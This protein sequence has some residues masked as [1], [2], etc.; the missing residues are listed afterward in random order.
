M[1]S[2]GGE[3]RRLV[4]ERG[5]GNGRGD[6][7]EAE[8]DGDSELD[9][10]ELWA[11]G[12]RYSGPSTKILRCPCNIGQFTAGCDLILGNIAGYSSHITQAKRG[13]GPKTRAGARAKVA[14]G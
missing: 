11:R 5:G 12:D 13:A 10:G 8:E 2:S 14:R 1:G 3:V 9:L 7:V 4:V 6:E